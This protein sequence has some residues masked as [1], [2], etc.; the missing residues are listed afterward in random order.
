MKLQKRKVFKL[1]G[2]LH[3]I[4]PSEIVEQLGIKK[5]DYFDVDCEPDKIIYMRNK[6]A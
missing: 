5:G 3:I 2:S 4:I 6:E 1:S